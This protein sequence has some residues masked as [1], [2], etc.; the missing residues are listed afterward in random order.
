MATFKTRLGKKY[1]NFAGNQFQ[2]VEIV[3]DFG[4][5]ECCFDVRIRTGRD[6]LVMLSSEQCKTRGAYLYEQAMVGLRHTSYVEAR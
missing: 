3:G 1:T 5:V 2:R 6:G 4:V